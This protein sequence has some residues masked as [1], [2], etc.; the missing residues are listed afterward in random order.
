[1]ATSL[2]SVKPHLREAGVQM[3]SAYQPST[4]TRMFPGSESQKVHIPVPLLLPAI[5]VPTPTLLGGLLSYSGGGGR[6]LPGTSS[7]LSSHRLSGVLLSLPPCPAQV[8]SS[9]PAFGALGHR[10]Y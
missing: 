10:Q 4:C 8:L 1:M 5:P 3:S 6:D 7:W 9:R 2:F